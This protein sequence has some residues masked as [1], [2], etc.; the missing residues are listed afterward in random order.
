MTELQKL[1]PEQEAKFQVYVDKWLKIGLSTEQS[2]KEEREAAI[3]LAYTCAELEPPKWFLH[4]SSPLAVQYAYNILKILDKNSKDNTMANSSS[5]KEDDQDN[6]VQK[7]TGF[8][9]QSLTKNGLD[10]ETINKMISDIVDQ[11]VAPKDREEIDVISRA[12][13][14]SKEAILSQVR[15]EL[16]KSSSLEFKYCC[17]GSLSGSWISFYD[18]FLTEKIVDNID[19]VKGLIECA[20]VCGWFMPFKDFCIVGEKPNAIN[21]DSVGRLH[22]TDSAAISWQDVYELYFV[23]GVSVLPEVIKN[24]AN[25]TVAQIDA[26]QNSERKRILLELFGWDRYIL[27]SGAKVVHEDEFGKL[28]RTTIPGDED[29]VMVQ[30]EN[31]SREGLWVREGK[32]LKFHPVLN[33]NGEEYRKKYMLRVPP[34]VKTAREAVASTFGLQEK[35]YKPVYES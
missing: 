14:M 9:A 21:R 34:T 32:F 26:E 24:K 30:V 7:L 33:E 12:S 1:T 5:N 29:L 10:T 16:K 4:V 15:D 19:M 13:K 11:I 31:C 23:H 6:E 2:Q 25:I 3:N 18:F 17:Y 35:E 20:K 28:F 8:V 27:E 22:S